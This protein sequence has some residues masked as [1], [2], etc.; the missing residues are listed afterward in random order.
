MPLALRDP[1]DAKPG[2]YLS[3]LIVYA[4][5]ATIPGRENN[6]DGAGTLITFRVARPAPKTARP[7][8]R[9]PLPSANWTPYRGPGD[10]QALRDAVAKAL[11]G[12]TITFAD[13]E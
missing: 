10:V 7:A 8:R 9:W 13:P 4:S 2:R 12:M 11:P 6:N 5:M 1:A 3:D